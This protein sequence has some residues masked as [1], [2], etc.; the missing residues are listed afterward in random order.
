MDKNSKILI[1]AIILL[2]V[3]LTALLIVFVVKGGSVKRTDIEPDPIVSE[4]TAQVINPTVEKPTVGK[5]NSDKKV[6]E[7]EDTPEDKKVEEEPK[8]QRTP[9]EPIE[10]DIIFEPA[11]GFYEDSLTVSIRLPEGKTGT[12]YCNVNDALPGMGEEYSG[13]IS[14]ETTDAESPNVYFIEATAAFEDGSIVNV[15]ATY[16]V[17]KNV[18]SRYSTPVISICGKPEEL[19]GPDGILY[20]RNA[21]QMTGRDSERWVYLEMFSESGEQLLSQA[22][23]MRPFGG[24]SRMLPIKSVKLYARKEYDTSKN[25]KTDIFGTKK[26]DGS[27]EVISSYKRLVLRNTAN[28]F[29]SG[30]IRDEYAQMLAKEVGLPDAEGVLP[31]AVYING[32]YYG[33]LW[34]HESYCDKYFKEKYGDDAPGEFVVIEGKET[35]KVGEEQE[36][37]DFNAMYNYLCSLD[38]R[39]D[40]AFAEAEAFMDVYNYIDY[41]LFNIYVANLDWPYN[42][43]KC[44]RYYAA[45]GEE[46]GE[47]VFD[48]RWRFLPHD[49]DFSLSISENCTASSDIFAHVLLPENGNYYSPLFANLS[50]R[51]DIQNYVRHRLTGLTE[52]YL[53][54]EKTVALFDKADEMRAKEHVYMEAHISAMT[55]VDPNYG[56]GYTRQD[57]NATCEA[58]RTFLR[59][60]ND[61]ILSRMDYYYPDY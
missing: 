5:T 49:M 42:N 35:E 16:F 48:G 20:G 60:R 57:L 14:L 8:K 37:A 54:P 25:F 24:Y 1:L 39:E 7:K 38:M 27:D 55:A 11:A 6:K 51:R 40:T 56:S 59:E 61:N 28:D 34:L 41:Y 17:G 12:I 32:Q 23:G 44:Y 15:T 36:V 53:D 52:T 2:S 29:G 13:E 33:L 4:E 9:G 3:S 30:F 21:Q 10:R 50:K 58:I 31:T 43:I 19:T 46:Y 45:E 26:E 22:C 18:F 47:G